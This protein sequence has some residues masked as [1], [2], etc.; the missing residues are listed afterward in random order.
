MIKNV[1]ILHLLGF[2]L[3]ECS[4]FASP[5]RVFFFF[6]PGKQAGPPR[7]QVQGV[8]TPARKLYNR[9]ATLSAGVPLF[10]SRSR[11]GYTLR[12]LLP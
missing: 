2:F 5:E 7:L 3:F 4:A 9:S 10:M 8:A 12:T 6:P 1:A 11:H